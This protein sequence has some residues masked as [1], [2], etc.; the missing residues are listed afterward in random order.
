MRLVWLSVL[1]VASAFAHSQFYGDYKDVS[2]PGSARVA[3]PSAGIDVRVDQRLNEYVPLQSKFKDE[4]G[5]AITLGDYFHNRPV[6][7]LPIFYKCPGIC[8]TEL[9]SL[10]DSLKGFKKD[11]VGSEF[12]VVV[13]SIDPREKPDLAA[14]KKDTVV[15]AYMGPVTNHA[16]RVNAEKGWHFLTGDLEN[17]NQV[18]NA[19]GFRYTFDKSNGS[20]VHPA[21]IMVVTPA[22]K[23]SRYFVATQ[24]P[25]RLL[26]DSIRDAG[27]ELTGVRDDRPFFLAC[28]QVNPLTGQ[29]TMNILNTLKTLGVLTILSILVSIVV[30]NRKYKAEHGGVL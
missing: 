25:Q 10:V 2:P 11:F 5:K 1:I 30:W 22:G 18:C 21:G 16:R 7:V 24:Y 3:T 17:I 14:I 9:Y 23:I 20:I 28:V 8:E 6:V 29:R 12:D 4:D 19:L 15:A 26:L 13:L 27:K